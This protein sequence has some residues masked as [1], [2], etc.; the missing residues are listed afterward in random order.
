MRVYKNLTI[1]TSV[2]T[3]GSF[4]VALLLQY[5]FQNSNFWID[6]LL[7]IFSG[8]LLTVLTSIISYHYER[9]KTLESF[10]YHTRQILLYLNKYQDS[11]SLE[12]K[13]RF[14]LDYS[15]LDKTAWDMDFGS[16]D[17]FFEKINGNNEYVYTRLY[18]PI[19]DFNTAVN[20]RVQSFRYHLD[21]KSKN[22]NVML[23]FVNEL[24]NYLL[25][26]DERDCPSEYDESGN[27]ISFCR[28]KSIQ[29]KLVSN[30]MEE[31][32]GRYYKI[33]YGKRVPENAN[34]EFETQSNKS[35]NY[36]L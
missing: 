15:E 22:D 7:G 25:Q 21:N 12:E 24:Q 32:N 27:P 3:I 17:F 13:L 36:Q 1:I 19:L 11:M 8:A 2:I 16:L 23:S 20:K 5:N 26:I 14:F 33:M 31:L 9:R 30:I 29:S 4:L 28:Y 35:T 18:K 6:I 10:V 34:N